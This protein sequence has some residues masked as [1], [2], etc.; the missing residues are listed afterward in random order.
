MTIDDVTLSAGQAQLLQ[1][2]AATLPYNERANFRNSV[3]AQLRGT[4]TLLAVETAISIVLGAKPMFS[5]ADSNE[6][7]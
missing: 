3:L 5:A 7:V 6:G 2:H 1:R 4:P